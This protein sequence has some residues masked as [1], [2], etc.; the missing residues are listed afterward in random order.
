MTQR[1]TV[2][3]VWHIRQDMSRP[4]WYSETEL[5]AV[6]ASKAVAEEYCDEDSFCEEME[7]TK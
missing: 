6:C 5:V 2:W 4:D 1:E 7:V 3:L